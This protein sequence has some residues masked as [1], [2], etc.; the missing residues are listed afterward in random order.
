MF[1]TG[2]SNSVPRRVSVTCCSVT[3]CRMREVT[4]PFTGSAGTISGTG[5]F[6]VL[7]RWIRARWWR[8]L[9]C[10]VNHGL[11]WNSF[12]S[13]WS[14]IVAM[15]VQFSVGLYMS[16]IDQHMRLFVNVLEKRDICGIYFQDLSSSLRR[17][18]R[19]KSRP[20]RR[21]ADH[22]ICFCLRTLM[23]GR[24]IPWDLS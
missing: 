11:C 15:T 14:Y 6:K 22:L 3:L 9:S 21:W 5:M 10:T 7:D 2:S 12:L 1:S 20:D 24:K 16:T 17:I 13:L 23:M 4:Q 19:R 18:S 8:M